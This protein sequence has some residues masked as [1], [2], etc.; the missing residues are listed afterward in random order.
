M[1]C[2]LLS[3]QWLVGTVD[4]NCSQTLTQDRAAPSPHMILYCFVSLSLLQSL[5]DSGIQQTN[6]GNEIRKV[7]SKFSHVNTSPFLGK[8]LE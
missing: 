3:L 2:W 5:V 1:S 8:N 6:K 7:I 4:T